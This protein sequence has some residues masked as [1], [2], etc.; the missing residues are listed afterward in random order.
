MNAILT[1]WGVSVAI[2]NHTPAGAAVIG[3]ETM[4]KV[5]PVFVALMVWLTRILIIG[6]FAIAGERLFSMAGNRPAYPPA[7]QPQPRQ[8]Y[9]MTR[10]APAAPRPVTAAPLTTA[11][12]LMNSE[13]ATTPPSRS[14]LPGG[15][16]RPEPTYHPMSLAAGAL[17][18][19]PPVRR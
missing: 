5:V 2:S 3:A 17:D 14:P 19:D 1:W 16:T 10:P 9:T 7:Y 12:A 13:R 8:S 18:E 6:S 4:L 11:R 15:V